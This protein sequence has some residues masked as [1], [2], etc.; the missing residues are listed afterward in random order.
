[1]IEKFGTAKWS[2]GL[3]DGQ[4]TV[5]T[6]TE[7]LKDVPY[8]FATRFENK[9]GMN[10]EELLGAAHAA[11]FSMAL[12]GELGKR[13]MT[14]ESIETKSTLTLVPG[15]GITKAHLT[16]K[17]KVPGASADGFKEA[18]DAAKAGCPVSKLFKAEITLDA[19]LV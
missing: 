13:G 15:E 2:G 7:F 14:A 17:A 11:C 5:S 4:G 10:P 8:T 9:A 16:L 1:M 6:Q 12:S 3:K 19:E 18:A